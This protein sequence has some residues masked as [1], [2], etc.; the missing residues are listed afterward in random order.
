MWSKSKVDVARV[1]TQANMLSQVLS[2]IS[3]LPELKPIMARKMSWKKRFVASFCRYNTAVSIFPS[4]C[5]DASAT[6][7]TH[8]GSL[9]QKCDVSIAT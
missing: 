7:R 8:G 3:L 5:L 6:A 4:V 2:V 9:L 1:T